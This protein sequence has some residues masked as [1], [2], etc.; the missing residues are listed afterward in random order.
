M[1]LIESTDKC[2]QVTISS[3]E[4]RHLLEK[5]TEEEFRDEIRNCNEPELAVLAEDDHSWLV[6]KAAVFE[7]IARGYLQ[8]LHD[9]STASQSFADDLFN[10]AVSINRV[11]AGQFRGG[12]RS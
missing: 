4:L 3:P 7:A 9:P 1:A 6:Y 10:T 2:R 11:A 8:I 5:T 12:A